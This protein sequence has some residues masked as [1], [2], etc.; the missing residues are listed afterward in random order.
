MLNK[1]II[2]N[3]CSIDECVIDFKKNKYSFYEDNVIGDCVNPVALYGH[4]GSGKSAVFKAVKTLIAL[5]TT[6]VD[7][8]FP[9]IVNQFELVKYK[10]LKD[11]NLLIG[12]ILLDFDI[13]NQNYVY[14]LST[15][16]KNIIPL[17]SL[18]KN[19]EFIFK[20]EN[21]SIMYKEKEYP[22]DQNISKLVPALRILA[23]R[24]IE[25]SDI[26]SSYNYI[27]NFTFVD[28][29]LQSSMMPF[30]SSKLFSNISRFELMSQK[31]KEVRE[32]LKEYEEF[33]LYDIKKEDS[34]SLMGNNMQQYKVYM[35]DIPDVGLPIEMMSEGMKNQ[36]LLLSI[37]TSLPNDSVLFV[38]E[39]EQ[40][41]HP[42]TIISFLNVVKKKNVQL[43]FSSHNTHILQH[44]R[45]DQIYFAKWEKGFSKYYRLSK[46]HPNIREI[47]NI[48]KMYLSNTFDIGD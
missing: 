17:E 46:I 6:S 20:Y 33:P 47:N 22:L 45:P 34:D 26:L 12:S 30:V 5:Q 40:A 15:S 32:L 23:S 39:L 38:D 9:F 21:G 2:K 3:V 13:G 16:R 4:N 36:S 41:L 44:L 28:L 48:E 8:L 10:K 19:G 11:E 7:F 18:Q 14:Y 29:P 1:L 25:D 37:L 27:S 24:E 42:S 43:L 31:S 35:D